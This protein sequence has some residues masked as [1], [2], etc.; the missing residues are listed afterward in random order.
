MKTAAHAPFPPSRSWQTPTRKEA[1]LEQPSIEQPIR[2][3]LRRHLLALNYHAFAHCLCLLLTKIG[4]EDV[5]VAG[6]TH[7]KG[8]NCEGGYDIE[9]YLPAGVGRR[10]V[11]VQSKQFDTLT[12]YQ[13]SVDEL[14]GTCLR[15]GADEALLITTSAFSPVVLQNAETPAAPVAPVRLLAGQELLNLLILH[16]IGVWE[17]VG[18][19]ESRMA[20]DAPCRVGVDTAFFE[21][22]SRTYP[23]N[24]RS[25]PACAGS[26]AP[27]SL[28][29]TV[30]LNL[31]GVARKEGR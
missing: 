7:W 28:L 27:S 30:R 23:G 14:R 17:E 15:A 21:E 18:R 3:Q 11:I 4:Y 29:L 5:Q 10:K 31:P 8:R 13:R 20:G 12:V 16:R 6:R 25:A 9:A 22:L 1:V 2:S 19:T 26:E 24:R